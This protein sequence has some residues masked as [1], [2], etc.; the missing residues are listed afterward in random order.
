MLNFCS[1]AS[2]LIALV[3]AART[4]ITA[5]LAGVLL[6][7]M[8]YYNRKDKSRGHQIQLP[9]QSVFCY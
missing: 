8:V 6:R 5:S 3:L 4:D 2:W 9:G 7:F 1:M